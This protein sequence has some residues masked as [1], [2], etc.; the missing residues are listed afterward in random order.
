MSNVEGFQ[1]EVVNPE[2]ERVYIKKFFF[3]IIACVF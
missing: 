2:L 3:I 1:L